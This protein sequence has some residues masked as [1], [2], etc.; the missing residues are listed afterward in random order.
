MSRCFAISRDGRRC[1]GVGQ[2]AGEHF[3]PA[4][5]L[6]DP[7]AWSSPRQHQTDAEL[8]AM[9]R[10]ALLAHYGE[11]AY[12]ERR[13]GGVTVVGVEGPGTVLVR[14]DGEAT[15]VDTEEPA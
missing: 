1:I 3:A 4:T 15:L 5:V 8:G 14:V 9:L 7:V 12:L 2:H 6:N 10:A 11:Q 13:V